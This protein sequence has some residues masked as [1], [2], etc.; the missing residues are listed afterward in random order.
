LYKKM[1]NLIQ[2]DPPPSIKTAAERTRIA[3][4]ER[5]IRMRGMLHLT[6][7]QFE[8]EYN[9]SADTLKNW[10]LGRNTG[11]TLQGGKRVIEAFKKAGIHCSIGWLLEGV[12]AAPFILHSTLSNKENAASNV[13][14]SEKSYAVLAPE[15]E[16]FCEK[17]P[18]AF[19]IQVVDDG[20]EPYYSVDDYVAGERHYDEEINKTIGQYCIVETQMG[21]ILLRRVRESLKTGRYSL[22]CINILTSVSTPLIY[23]VELA[24]AAPVQLHR[25]M[26]R[27]K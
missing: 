13:A 24:S 1:A 10:E 3:R 26:R 18:R 8:K 23:D 7:D 11:L 6:R 2:A 19:C 12:G 16:L 25:K 15:M 4:G 27:N 21:E 14:E 20:M 5:L 9:I 22:Q 17:N